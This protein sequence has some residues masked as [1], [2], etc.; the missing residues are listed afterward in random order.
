MKKVICGLLCAMLGVGTAQASNLT[1]T[2]TGNNNLLSGTLNGNPFSN[3]AYSIT[4]TADPATMVSGSFLG[5]IPATNIQATPTMTLGSSTFTLLP[6]SGYNWCVA[7]VD[8]SGFIPGNS[9]LGFMAVDPLSS[10]TAFLDEGIGIITAAALP[11]MNTAGTWTQSSPLT[12]PGNVLIWQTSAG[13]LVIINQS[14]QNV[15]TFTISG[16]TGGGGAV[17]EPG[18]WAAMGVLGAG[19]TGLVLRKRKKA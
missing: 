18:E 19:L 7:F 4:A 5:V 12:P 6:T 16:T 13:V 15:G 10:G 8:F 11:P 17:P 9:G 2:L 3:L 14:N 1:Y